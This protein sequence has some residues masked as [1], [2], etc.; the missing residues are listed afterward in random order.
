MQRI[1]KALVSYG[2]RVSFGR[3]QKIINSNYVCDILK[4]TFVHGVA[5]E[6]I[7]SYI[8]GLSF[9]SR[10][11]T[12]L[13]SHHDYEDH[14][15][16]DVVTASRFKMSRHGPAVDQ[17]DGTSLKLVS[18]TDPKTSAVEFNVEPEHI[19]QTVALHFN[20]TYAKTKYLWVIKR[21][22]VVI[23]PKVLELEVD[24]VMVCLSDF[25]LKKQKKTVNKKT[26]FTDDFSNQPFVTQTSFVGLV[27]VAGSASLV[28]LIAVAR[29]VEQHMCRHCRGPH[30]PPTG[31]KRHER[32]DPAR[33][34]TVRTQQERHT[35]TLDL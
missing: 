34:R 25:M 3:W 22:G 2:I 24:R 17:L 7:N 28:V 13:R 9:A 27:A 1:K 32:I 10:A 20:E 11:V 26:G 23:N 14:L 6:T 30:H 21:S 5:T 8:T 15:F 33:D 19:C 35:T 16:V 12:F 4:I 29:L 31:R 18:L